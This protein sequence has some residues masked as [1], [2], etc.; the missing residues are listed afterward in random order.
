MPPTYTEKHIKQ[1]NKSYQAVVVHTFNPS[2]QEFKAS[3][4]YTANSKE[5]KVFIEQN[6]VSKNKKKF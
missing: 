1:I 4:V 6:P 2:T 5:A 3:L